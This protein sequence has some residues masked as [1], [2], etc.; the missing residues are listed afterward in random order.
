MPTLRTLLPFIF[1]SLL[2]A[3]DATK[4][5]GVSVDVDTSASPVMVR[6]AYPGLTLA[7]TR[8]LLESKFEA[9]EM[10]YT[11]TVSMFVLPGATTAQPPF[12]Q[13][14][15]NPKPPEAVRV[16]SGVA[17]GLVVKRVAPVYPSEAKAR[18]IEGLVV[19]SVTIGKDGR[20]ADVRGISGHPVL[21]EAAQVA[22]AQWEYKPFIVGDQPVGLITEVEVNFALQ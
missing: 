12:M 9:R 15:P 7:A 17:R 11:T 21:M 2:C 6:A 22:V 3:Q 8:V 4:E 13:T 19:L 1:A 5:I 14:D 16:G 18:R 10:P 20:V